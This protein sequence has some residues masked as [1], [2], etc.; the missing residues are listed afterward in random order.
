MKFPTK[1]WIP[2]AVIAALIV[3]ELTLR[4]VLGLGNPVLFQA[5]ADTGYRYQPNRTVFR[6][7]NKIEFNQYSQRSEA[8][9]TPKPQGM[10]RILMTGD[11]ITNGGTLTDQT[12]IISELLEARLAAKTQPVEVLNASAGSWGIGNQLAYLRKFGTF[13]SDAAIAQIG[14]DDLIQPTSTSDRVGHDPSYPDRPP[15]LAIQELLTRYARPRLAHLLRLGSPSTNLS[16]PSPINLDRQFQENLQH[17]SAI[18]T[19]VRTQRIPIFVLFTPNLNNL[20]PTFNEPKYKPELL[21][22]LNALRV[23][24]IDAHQAWS[25]LPKTTVETFYQPDGIHLT[26]AG[27]QAIANLLFE[28]LCTERQLPTCLL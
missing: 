21:Q 17:L 19:L 2:G 9:I 10:L 6:F 13:D 7:G 25:T 8:V 28:R 16:P 15:V 24:V 23:S 18:I 3:T 20:V 22:F 11:S 1:Y 12:Q 14:T 5:D 26:V 27:N 4:L